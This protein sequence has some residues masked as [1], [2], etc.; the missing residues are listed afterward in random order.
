[1]E[2]ERLRDDHEAAVLA[3]ETVNRAHFGAS[4]TDRGEKAGFVPVG[5]GDVGGRPGTLYRRTLN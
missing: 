4:I 1:M 2:L 5:T 3:F